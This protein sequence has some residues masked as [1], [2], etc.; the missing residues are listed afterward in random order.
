M[1]SGT[2]DFGARIITRARG[3]EQMMQADNFSMTVFFSA[4]RLERLAG[5]GELLGE[6]LAW[7][8][9]DCRDAVELSNIEGG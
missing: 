4:V 3:L 5:G 1:G 7:R 9:G 6:W 2:R 8:V